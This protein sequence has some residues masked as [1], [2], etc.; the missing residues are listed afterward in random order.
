MRDYAYA[1]TPD[2]LMHLTLAT[3]FTATSR[4]N[5]TQVH[6]H[7]VDISDELDAALS[8]QDYSVPIATGATQAQNQLNAWTAIGAAMMVTAAHPAGKDSKHLEFLERR[9]NAILSGISDGSLSLDAAQDTSVSL[10]RYGGAVAAEGASPYFGRDF[11]D[12]I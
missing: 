6:H 4:P 3:A 12:G 5:S 11:P 9:W 8:S 7:L 1:S 10:P 2:V